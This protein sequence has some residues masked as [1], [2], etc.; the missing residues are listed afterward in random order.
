MTTAGRPH[1]QLAVAVRNWG[2]AVEHVR[3]IE[4]QLQLANRQL[5]QAAEQLRVHGVHI[6][7]TRP[8]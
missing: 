7:L 1:D 8:T 5:D 3:S 2:A 6:Q 4:K